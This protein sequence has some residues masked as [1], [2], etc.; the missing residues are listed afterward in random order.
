MWVRA[1]FPYF[2]ETIAKKRL[3]NQ[4]QRPSLKDEERKS[5]GRVWGVGGIIDKADQGDW[6]IQTTKRPRG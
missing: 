3:T 6:S 5:R 2:Y 1:S 4:K